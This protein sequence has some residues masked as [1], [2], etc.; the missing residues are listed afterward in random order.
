MNQKTQWQRHLRSYGAALIATAAFLPGAAALMTV[1][2][3]LASW[4][5]SCEGEYARVSPCW[6]G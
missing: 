3:F 5:V 1:F 4:P 6:L 2:I